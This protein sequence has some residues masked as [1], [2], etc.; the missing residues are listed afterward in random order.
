[1]KVYC[2]NVWNFNPSEYRNTLIASLIG[3]FDADVCCFQECGPGTNRAG[4][5][6]LPKLLEATYSEVCP[7]FADRNYTGLFYKTEKYNL[8][9]SGYFLYTGLNDANSKSVA[10]AVIEDKTTQKRVLVGSTHFWWMF[11]GED[12]NLQRLQNVAELK[13]FCEKMTKEYNIPAIIGGDFN[14]G[15]NSEQGEEPYNKMIQEGFCD[16][17]HTAEETTDSFTHHEYPI[18]N[19]EGIYVDGAMPERN[20]D[21]IF[22]Y[23]DSEIKAKKFEILTTQ[24]ALDSSDHCPLLATFEIEGETTL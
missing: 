5:A 23:G 15:I 11:R 14:N 3:D 2:Q 22:T 16:V 4:A 9:D 6:P 21:Y 24:K 8:I 17:R 13:A 10:W 7:E 20:L 12:D 1:M 18:L 19:D